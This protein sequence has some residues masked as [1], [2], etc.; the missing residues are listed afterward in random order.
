M[1][2]SRE[3]MLL[4]EAD[5]FLQRNTLVI[6]L[7]KFAKMSCTVEQLPA[8]SSAG[9]TANGG[10]PASWN[11]IKLSKELASAVQDDARR[12]AIDAAKKRAVSQHV[13]YETFQVRKNP[14]LVF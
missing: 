13:D 14:N 12:K 9:G 6:R 4:R 8:A 5:L 1:F 11:R 7:T 10:A 3:S 2:L